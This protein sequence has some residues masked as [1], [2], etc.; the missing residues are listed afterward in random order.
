MLYKL[1]IRFIVTIVWVDVMMTDQ[2]VAEGH[3]VR[4]QRRQVTYIIEEEI[5]EYEVICIISPKQ[6]TNTKKRNAQIGSKKRLNEAVVLADAD[7]LF[8]ERKYLKAIEHVASS[9]DKSD[10]DKL[11]IRD[12][13]PAEMM[14]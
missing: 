3:Q 12:E 7:D 8:K 9:G 4:S 10:F 11:D 5:V 14:I 6:Y 1:T 13:R 2:S